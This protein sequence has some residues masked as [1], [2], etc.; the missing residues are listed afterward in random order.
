VALRCLI[1]DDSREFLVSAARL[2]ESQGMRVIAHASTSA[3]ALHL[4]ETL[5]PDVALVDVEL[6]AEDG[7]ELARQLAERAPTVP[8]ILIST[9]EPAE[10]ADL[11]AKTPAVGFLPKDVLGLTAILGLLG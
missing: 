8:V 9:H 4:A 6:G 10:L 11:V 1:A 3:A 7:L 5:L 2:L